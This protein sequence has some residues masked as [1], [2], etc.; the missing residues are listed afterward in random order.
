MLH[1]A[2]KNAGTASFTQQ[3]EEIYNGFNVDK[4]T[5]IV[6]LDIISLY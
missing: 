6:A 4:N 3:R 1:M 2:A 5:L